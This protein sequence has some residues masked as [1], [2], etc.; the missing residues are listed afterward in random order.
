VESN[1]QWATTSARSLVLSFF[2]S[3]RRSSGKRMRDFGASSSTSAREQ[4]FNLTA[5]RSQSTGR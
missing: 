4:L 5:S 3:F 2:L 1:R